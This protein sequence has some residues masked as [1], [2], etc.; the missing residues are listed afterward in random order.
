MANRPGQGRKRKPTAAKVRNGSAAKDPG[1]IN[2]LEPAAL[3]DEPTCPD[4]LDDV[5]RATWHRTCDVMR[6]MGYLSASYQDALDI[7]A[8]TYS[9][10]RQALEAVEKYGQVLVSKDKNGNLLVRRNPFSVEL[11]KY[12][13]E[14][15]KIL[16]EFGL[17]PSS[18]TRVSGDG[19]KELDP[20][21]AILQQRQSLN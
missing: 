16:Q 20:L 7:Y 17:T 8:E 18:K 11:H 9:N 21:S 19:P 6:R 3:S 10:Y 4:H 12:H 15:M 2:K 13:D 5:G 1:R 14:L